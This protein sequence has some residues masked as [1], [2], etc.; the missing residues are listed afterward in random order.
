MLPITRVLVPTDFSERCL[1][2]LPYVRTIA[3]KHQ[4]EVIL[5][6][7]I[8][9]FYTIPPTGFSGPV[10]VPVSGPM[11]AERE[12]MMG[13]FGVAELRDCKVERRVQEGDPVA[14]IVGYAKTENVSLIAMPTHGYGALRRFLIGSITSKVLHDAACPVLTGA[15]AEEK[16]GAKAVVFSTILAAV[17]LGPQ[18]E[19]VL[20]WAAQM[21][22]DFKAKLGIVHSITPLD[23]GLP[24]KATPQFRMELEAAARS[25]VEKLQAATKTQGAALHLRSGEPAR[26]VSAL[27]DSLGA[28]LLVIG[29]GPKDRDGGRLPT[30]AYAIIRKSPCAVVSV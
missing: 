24:Y 8:D 22:A 6:H 28:E 25:E 14:Q 26:E 29:R 30:N 13:E 16:A 27:A 11:I 1:G 21:A 7:V 10:V 23:A 17:D 4:A 3:E 19:E 2:M 5:L 15:H 18:S 20:A 9:P 12:R